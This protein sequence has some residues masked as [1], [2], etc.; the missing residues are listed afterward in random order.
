M[1]L[2]AHTAALPPWRKRWLGWRAPFITAS[3]PCSHPQTKLPS[4]TILIPVD[5]AVP[6][7]VRQVVLGPAPRATHVHVLPFHSPLSITDTQNQEYLAAVYL[8]SLS[9]GGFP[10]VLLSLP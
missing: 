7:E 10:L 1:S 2:A 5:L 6:M 9:L 8:A 4:L 3:A